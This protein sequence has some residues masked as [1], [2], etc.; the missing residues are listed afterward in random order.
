MELWSL[1]MLTILGT[2]RIQ[3]TVHKGIYKF[4]SQKTS[5]ISGGR[6]R[7]ALHME[8]EISGGSIKLFG[9]YS[10]VLFCFFSYTCHQR[11]AL[12]ITSFLFLGLGLL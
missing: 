1:L 5:A 12:L 7:L 8:N 4:R 10:N 2:L 6:M 9:A 3:L 11:A